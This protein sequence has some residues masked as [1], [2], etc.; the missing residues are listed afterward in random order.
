[1]SIRFFIAGLF[2]FFLPG[3][4]LY[5]FIPD[6]IGCILILCAISRCALLSLAMEDAR[7]SFLKL[8]YLSLFRLFSAFLLTVFFPQLGVQQGDGIETLLTL[9]FCGF[10]LA[11]GIFAFRS[12]Y[13]G[14]SYLQTRYGAKDGSLSCS[15]LKTATVAFLIVKHL[16]NVLPT[17]GGLFGSQYSSNVDRNVR[18]IEEFSNLLLLV[19]FV[20]VT[21]LGIV[22]LC[23]MMSALR[24][25]QKQ[26]A[27]MQQLND[28][29]AAEIAMRPQYYLRQRIRVITLL[30][31][32]AGFFSI[33]LAVDRFFLL[34]DPLVAACLTVACILLFQS[35]Y[36][37]KKGLVF[38]GISF[39]LSVAAEISMDYYNAELADY[40][41]YR[42]LQS[43]PDVLW[44]YIGYTTL[45]LLWQASF[46]CLLLLLWKSLSSIA[47]E[48]TGLHVNAT[49][50]RETEE[51]A[52]VAQSLS[53]SLRNAGILGIALAISS[54]IY[55]YLLPFVPIYWLPQFLLG[56]LFAVRVSES[57]G[58]LYEQVEYKYT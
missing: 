18:G 15:D 4:G 1:M 21:I 43:H 17:L 49:S 37:A 28:S 46:V 58:A 40:A 45:Q 22:W 30:L 50:E 2:F 19:N 29:V 14:L 27:F 31:I 55:A 8:T 36:L 41:L 10:E 24:S 53:Q 9:L 42:G 38:C 5:D 32:A 39:V 54:V 13:E 23:L 25:M 3:F 35:G 16:L 26:T 6:F 52:L 47:K 33:D 44:G 57:A 7:K 11:Y 51:N 12:F 34:P 56:V 48:H 20:L